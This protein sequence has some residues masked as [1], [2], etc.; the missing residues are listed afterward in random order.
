MPDLS[1][2]LDTVGA[3]LTDKALPALLLLALG[4]VAIR[5]TMRLVD[6]A[7]EKTKLEPILVR[8]VRT[9]GRIVLYILLALMVADK[10]GIDV[11]GVVALASVLTLAISLSVQDALTNLIG[12]FTL[13]YTKPF[14]IGDY[15]EIG[16]EC[17]TVKK[18]GLTYTQILT[19]DRKT[20]S[21]PNKSVVA[22]QRKAVIASSFFLRIQ[23]PSLLLFRLYYTIRSYACQ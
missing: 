2:W 19:P 6:K 10:I 18:I 11:T 21:I 5:L 20:V 4:I 23:S 7:L 12:G 22:A 16:G 17:G 8:L 1:T 14:Q 13:L 15:V 3:Y 9:A